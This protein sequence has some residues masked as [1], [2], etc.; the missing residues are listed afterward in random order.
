MFDDFLR[1]ILIV[2]LQP[3]QNGGIGN[4]FSKMPPKASKP[5]EQKISSEFTNQK[6]ES[7]EGTV[8]NGISDVDMVDISKEDTKIK[9]ENKSERTN[10]D[11]SQNNKKA[12]L[13]KSEKTKSET[14]SSSKKRKKQ[15]KNNESSKKR[16]RIQEVCDS[17]SDGKIFYC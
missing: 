3:K 5:T 7:S 1:N 15:S 14:S 9:I 17:D 2:L 8:E 10:I 6:S 12:K 11:A 13:E 16:K 4:F